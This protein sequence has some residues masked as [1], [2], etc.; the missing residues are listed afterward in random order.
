MKRTFLFALIAV[1][2]LLAL[3]DLLLRFLVSPPPSRPFEWPPP[4]MTK[5]GLMADDAL[6]W[7]LRPGYNEPWRLYKL[8]Y[9][10]ELGQN[11][12][13]DWEARKQAV[14]PAYRGVTW[15]VNEA[16]FRGPMIPAQKPP[17][18]I[19]LLFL[20]SSITFGWGVAARDAFPEKVRE[21]LE[22]AFPGRP[23]EAI[24]AGVPGYSSYQGLRCLEKKILPHYRP[25]LVVAE[26]GINDGT[27]AVGKADK[28]CGPRFSEKLVRAL[29]ES[30]WGR[31]VLAFFRP[32][33][34]KTAVAERRQTRQQAQENFYRVGMTGPLTRVAAGDFRANLEAMRAMCREHGAL[35]FPAIP[36]LYNEYG[37]KNVISAVNLLTPE[38]IS[39]HRIISDSSQGPLESLFLPYDE[40]HL[41]TKGHQVVAQWM[42]DFLKPRVEELLSEG[43]RVGNR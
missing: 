26:F 38:T 28:D 40:G 31:L 23:F 37:Q 6:F 1:V 24:N 16:G 21:G 18:T 27:T 43:E 4:D 30:G 39:F 9:T 7:K 32:D 29:R 20:G 10:C 35:F 15:E 34:S 22:E 12:S 25:N 8:A 14:A 5:H 13:I 41:S 33:V 2:T 19:R 36:A 3:S 11:E 17:G 42:V